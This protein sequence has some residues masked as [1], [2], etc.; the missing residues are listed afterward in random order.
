MKKALVLA[1]V[2]SIVMVQGCGK[3]S[4]ENIAEKQIEHQTGSEENVGVSDESDSVKTKNKELKMDAVNKTKNLKDERN[5]KKEE[6]RPINVSDDNF[7]DEVLESDIPV[8]VDFWAP[9]CGPCRMAAPVLEKIAQEYQGKLKVCKLNV[10]EGRQTAMKYSI[11]GIPTLNIYKDGE[12]V[13][14]MIGVSPN[15]ESD[16]KK[17]IESNIY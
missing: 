1:I 2:M 7:E 12:V 5:L 10:D 6:A 11:S 4:E 8:L 15:Y 14:Q 9:W 13:D 3:K 17:K 16:L